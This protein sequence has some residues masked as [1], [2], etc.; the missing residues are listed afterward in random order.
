MKDSSDLD[1][2]DSFCLVGLIGLR[3]SE[4]SLSGLRSCFCGFEVA[5]LNSSEDMRGGV[6]GR[7]S[8]WSLSEYVLLLPVLILNSESVGLGARSLLLSMS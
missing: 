8:R 5:V 6:I 3:V 4:S 2:C 7:Y 1:T